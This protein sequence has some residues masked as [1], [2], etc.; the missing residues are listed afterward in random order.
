MSPRDGWLLLPKS[1]R[2]LPPD[3]AGIAAWVVL[4]NTVIF[5]PIFSDTP[6]RIV[7]GLPFILFVPGYALIAALFPE[8]GSAP[9]A[10]TGDDTTTGTAEQTTN[11]RGI[12]GIERVALASGLS[13][14]IVPLVG[15]GLNFTPWGIRLVPIMV[16]TSGLTLA[17]TAVAARRRWE[18]P[19]ERRLTVPTRSWYHG[20]KTELFEPNGRADAALNVLL[21]ASLLLATASVGFAVFVPSQGESFSELY[22]LTETENGDLVADDYPTD[23]TL[24]ERAELTVGVTNQEHEQQTYVVVAQLQRV[25]TTGNQTRVTSSEELRRFQ[26][27]L[28]HNE[29]WRRQH[30]ITPT[31]VGERLRLQYLLYRAPPP[32]TGEQ[33]TAY[34]DVHLWVNVSRAGG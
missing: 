2:Q 29:T 11:D 33:T 4:T 16:A 31:M 1:V 34:R 26:T 20:V 30:S 7:L 18:L 15:L 8:A 19:P 6:L 5:L 23:L 13:I 12:D 17:L 10:A 3:L 32:T 21:V 25:T 28:G 24:G 22:L 27:T 9:S 14:A